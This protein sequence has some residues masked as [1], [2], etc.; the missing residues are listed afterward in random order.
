MTMEKFIITGGKPL[1][2]TI[3]VAGAK[4]AALKALVAACLT[5]DEVTINNFPQIS[6]LHIMAEIIKTL[7][8]SITIKDHTVTVKMKHIKANPIPLDKAA[9]IRTSVMFVAPLLVR[10]KEAII[11]NPGGDRIGSRP[12]DRIV[13][14]LQSMGAEIQYFEE[15]GYF[16]AKTDGL[17]GTEYT[18]NKNSHTGTE[19]LIMAA[20]LAKGTTV[21]KNAAQEP[22]VD[23]LIE[24]M[25]AMGANI[26]RTKEREITVVGVEKLHGAEITILPDRNEIVTFAVGAYVTKGDILV[27]EATEV[28]LHAFLEAL[29]RAHASYKIEGKDIRFFADK[30]LVAT[31]VTTAI[32][33][34]FMTD[35]QAPWAV[36]MTQAK[37]TTIIHETVF[38]NRFSYVNE[39]KKMGAHI[40]P[41]NIP[42]KNPDLVYNFNLADDKPHLSRAIH[43]EGPTSLHNA[44]MTISDLRAGATLVLA[45]LCAKG[46]T[47]IFGLEQVDRGYEQFEQRLRSLGADIQRIKEK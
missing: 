13:K 4:N 18:L 45:A 7:H 17:I 33:P 11:P 42:V 2:G 43:V 12:I 28:D 34:G 5:E 30:E 35:W 39:L 25:V 10:C 47:T 37:G 23:E 14:G 46:T 27:Q 8:G 3:R 40:A 22:E 1:K 32:H 41:I 16:H 44:V 26:Q 15:D 38:E 31:D 19:T 29:D 20:S 6:D 24:L 9:L 36:L 21:L